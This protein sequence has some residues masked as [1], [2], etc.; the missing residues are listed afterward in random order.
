M[1][2]PLAWP[3]R[4]TC[5][6]R[7]KDR[8]RATKD[9]AAGTQSK[10]HNRMTHNGVWVYFLENRCV[11]ARVCR[12]RPSGRR[13]L[14]ERYS[15]PD[16]P[17]FPRKRDSGPNTAPSFPRKRESS[18]PRNPVPP[19]VIPNQRAPDS[20]NSIQ[21]PKPRFQK[22][23]T[24]NGVLVYLLEER[25]V[26]AR[27]CRGRPG[28]RRCLPGRHAHPGQPAFQRKRDSGPDT[29]PSFPRKRESSPPESRAATRHPEPASPGQPE[30][31]PKS[32]IEIPK[33]IDGRTKMAR[34][35]LG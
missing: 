12:G 13:R 24:H 20:Q 28:G 29:V 4:A 16:L 27:V 21:I 9:G 10:F 18:P 5:W 34:I 19:H 25:C 2:P 30:P 33:S 23:M 11:P 3:G 22:G 15:H 31:N 8:R 14:P 7:N 1:E 32:A 26:P 17:S 35:Q 6:G